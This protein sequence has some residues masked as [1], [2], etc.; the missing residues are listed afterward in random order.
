MA[1]NNVTGYTSP[2]SQR[3]AEGAKVEV[4]RTELSVPQ[5]ETGATNATDSVSLTDTAAHLQ[6]LEN[7]IAALPVVDSQRVEEIRN[8]ITNGEYQIDAANIADKLI[9]LDTDLNR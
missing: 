9:N 6:K 2:H 3:S 5:Q 7:T 1:I 4:S 8:A